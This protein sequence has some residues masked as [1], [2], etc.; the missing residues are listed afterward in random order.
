MQNHVPNRIFHFDHPYINRDRL[1]REAYDPEGW[2]AIRQR[3]TGWQY[4]NHKP[5]NEHNKQRWPASW[6]LAEQ[7]RRMLD[8]DLDI[9]YYHFTPGALLDWHC[10]QNKTTV[11]NIHLT[12][13][14]DGITFR[15]GFHVYQTALINVAEEHSVRYITEDR[16]FL[17]FQI[18]GW[19][20]EDI[21]ARM[22]R[23]LEQT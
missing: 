18:G 20:F 19:P 21:V 17:K 6:M 3:V 10:D 9:K 11:V 16:V 15:D 22:K 5:V 23:V 13:T 14:H 2:M 8:V 12:D 1:R 4:I 7:F